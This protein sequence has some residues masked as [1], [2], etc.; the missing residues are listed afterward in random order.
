[1]NSWLSW[2]GEEGNQ[3]SSFMEKAPGKVSLSLLLFLR[4]RLFNIHFKIA[5]VVGVFAFIFLILT[6]IGNWEKH[7]LSRFRQ[8]PRTKND[9]RNQFCRQQIIW[10][11]ECFFTFIKKLDTSKD[12]QLYF[13]VFFYSHTYWFIVVRDSLQKHECQALSSFNEACK[14]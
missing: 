5:L 12:Q 9:V 6:C 7:F 1:M 4:K 3:L 14:F 8:Q 2:N 10:I 13:F 11:L